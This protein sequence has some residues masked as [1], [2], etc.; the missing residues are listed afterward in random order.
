MGR[1]AFAGEAGDFGGGALGSGSE[2]RDAGSGMRDAGCPPS[3]NGYG[4]RC[5]VDVN[6]T[7][8]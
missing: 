4:G 2:I 3:P 8:L 7:L 1:E 5:G 6:C